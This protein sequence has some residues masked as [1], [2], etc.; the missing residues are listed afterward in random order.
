MLLVGQKFVWVFHR[1]LWKNLNK[2][3][4]QPNTMSY[5]RMHDVL[6]VYII[7]YIKAHI[8]KYIHKYIQYMLYQTVFVS[9]SCNDNPWI[10]AVYNNKDLFLAPI[11]CHSLVASTSIPCLSHSGTLDKQT[12]LTWDILILGQ[13]DERND[14]NPQD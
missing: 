3:F 11:T 10:S 5:L 6:Y 4:G 2:L 8:K 7:Q 1:C 13:R 9:W 14:R 12:T